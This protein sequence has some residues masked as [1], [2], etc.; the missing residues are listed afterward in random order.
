M[1]RNEIAF[2]RI[3]DF[4]DGKRLEIMVNDVTFGYVDLATSFPFSRFVSGEQHVE[5]KFAVGGAKYNS[6]VVLLQNE[7]MIEGDLT[8]D[9]EKNLRVL[10]HNFSQIKDKDIYFWVTDYSFLVVDV[11][12]TQA[13]ESPE[14]DE[15]K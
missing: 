3:I 4:S 10:T 11:D 9:E 5:L 13:G 8:I 12:W 1:D 7:E 6:Q 14:V 15:C 2:H